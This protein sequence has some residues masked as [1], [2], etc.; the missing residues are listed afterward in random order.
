LEKV[1]INIPADRDFGSAD[2]PEEN[3]PIIKTTSRWPR[4]SGA[5][6]TLSGAGY[7]RAKLVAVG[8]RRP[9]LYSVDWVVNVEGTP[10]IDMTE[11]GRLRD[12]AARCQRLA[13]EAIASDVVDV[14]RE[15]AAYYVA[16]ARALEHGHGETPPMAPIPQ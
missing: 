11:A 4:C 2:P 8:A 6:S 15:L 1:A 3:L 16:R 7:P 10:R 12:Q 13:D 14:M 9:D 5:S